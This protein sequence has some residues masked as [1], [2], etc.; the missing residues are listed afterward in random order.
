[1]PGLH[2]IQSLLPG[3][4]L[5]ALAAHF[6]GDASYIRLSPPVNGI[7]DPGV[8]I[9][10]QVLVIYR[11]QRRVR[12]RTWTATRTIP[13]CGTTG[14]RP[15]RSAGTS[16]VNVL[17]PDDYR[18]S[19]RTYPVLTCS[20]AAAPTQDFRIV[21]LSKDPA[22]WTAPESRSSSRCPDEARGW[23]SNPSLRS[24]AHGTG[25]HSTSPAAPWI[26]A[27]FRT[28]AE[29]DGRAAGFRWAASRAEVR[30][31]YYGHFASASSHSRP[32]S[33][34]RDSRPGAHWA[35]VLGGA[36]FRR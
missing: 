36:G 31:K 20:T 18:T 1:M 12:L 19:G 16:G 5:S 6:G 23:Y 28:Y 3:T 15:P 35:N 13:A 29:Y 22:T 32:A 17:L 33:P 30:A 24:S 25:R 11:A 10:G 7:A 34:R 9:V 8:I 2:A 4:M 14:S 26:E 21:R 27:N